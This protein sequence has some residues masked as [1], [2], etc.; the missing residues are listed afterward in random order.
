MTYTIDAKNKILGRLASEIAVILQGKKGSD[1]EPRLAGE[2]KVVVKNISKI[3]V[4]GNKLKQKKYYRH[5]RRPGYLKE[6]VMGDVM[7]EDPAWVL[8]NAVRLMLPKNKLQKERLKRL[9]IEN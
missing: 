5:S 8:K 6:K 4:T 3:R 2:D 9:I 7:K 1:Y